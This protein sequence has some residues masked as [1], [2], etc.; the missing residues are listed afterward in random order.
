MRLPLALPL[1][2][3][4]SDEQRRRCD[5]ETPMLVASDQGVD[6]ANACHYR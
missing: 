6:H 5:G 1:Y 2:L 3:T 4:L